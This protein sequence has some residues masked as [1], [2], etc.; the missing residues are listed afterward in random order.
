[1]G[2]PSLLALIRSWLEVGVVGVSVGVKRGGRSGERRRAGER[3]DTVKRSPMK[4]MKMCEGIPVQK[5]DNP[6]CG[7]GGALKGEGGFV[8]RTATRRSERG[9]WI[10]QLLHRHLPFI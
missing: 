3:D 2:Q 7:G 10:E 4:Q 9:G 8:N 1:M 5:D 6:S